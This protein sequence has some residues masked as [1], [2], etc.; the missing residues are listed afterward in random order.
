[1][2]RVAFETSCDII[3]EERVNVIPIPPSV[4]TILWCYVKGPCKTSIHH[5]FVEVLNFSGVKRISFTW[6]TIFL[7]A[8]S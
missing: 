3:R 4:Y 5:I 2:N 1:M 7:F 6:G 8:N